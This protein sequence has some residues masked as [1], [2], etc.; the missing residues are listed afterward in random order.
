VTFERRSRRRGCKQFAGEQQIR[1][2]IPRDR[3]LLLYPDVGIVIQC[4]ETTLCSQLDR[5]DW[6]RWWGGFFLLI[7]VIG[8]AIVRIRGLVARFVAVASGDGFW[9]LCCCLWLGD[10]LGVFS[11]HE[12]NPTFNKQRHLTLRLI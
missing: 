11:A 12:I 4:W 8:L 3:V 1:F 7:G 6:S 5:R 9:R 2:A 10:F